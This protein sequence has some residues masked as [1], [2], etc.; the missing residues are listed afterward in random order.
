MHHSAAKASIN[1][2]PRA[3]L[4][5]V[6][7]EQLIRE[8]HARVLS[9]AG[10]DV[11]TVED[12]VA[13]LERLAEEEFD[14]VVTDRHLPKL[15]GASMVLA[16]R[17][18]GSRIPV[19][20]ISGSLTDTPLAPAVAREFSATLQKPARNAEVLSAVANALRPA[21]PVENL[22]HFRRAHLVAA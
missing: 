14:L 9:L 11:E 2:S 8:L 18:A 12:G 13:G 22:I 19:I 21:P 17:S 10:Y 5:V 4:L 16:M 15:D 20:M 7:D 3:R 1:E 6:D